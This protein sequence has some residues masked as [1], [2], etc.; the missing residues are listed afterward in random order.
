[1]KSQFRLLIRDCDG[2]T[3]TVCRPR[4]A[5]PHAHTPSGGEKD[6]GRGWRALAVAQALTLDK[7]MPIY[8]TKNVSKDQLIDAKCV[9]CAL[10]FFSSTLFPGPFTSFVLRR[11]HSSRP[12]HKNYI[13]GKSAEKLRLVIEL[14]WHE[15]VPFFISFFL[16]SFADLF[17]IWTMVSVHSNNI[18]SRV[19]MQSI[20]DDDLSAL[21]KV[22]WMPTAE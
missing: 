4:H 13:K 8:Q 11:V 16:F 15:A 21:L 14:F 17:T 9:S 20:V 12:N 6:V 1:M 2:A 19:Q 5:H 7:Q 3:N 10:F 22:D 18:H